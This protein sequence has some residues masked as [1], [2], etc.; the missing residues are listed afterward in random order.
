MSIKTIGD[1]ADPASLDEAYVR[2]FEAAGTADELLR[3]VY[4]DRPG[5]GGQSFGEMLAAFDVLLERIES[6]SWPATSASALNGRVAADYADPAVFGGGGVGKYID[7]Q[8][9]PA[10]RTWDFTNWGSYRA[11]SLATMTA[12]ATEVRAGQSITVRDEGFF[13]GET[14][15]LWIES[16]PVLL[17]TAVAGADGVVSFQVAI[18]A[19]VGGGAHTLRLVGLTS[20]T[21]LTWALTVAAMPATGGTLS[22]EAVGG[23]LALLVLGAG[24]VLLRRRRPAVS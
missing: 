5:H 8:P 4:I 16:T 14:V 12:S 19:E 21:Q 3:S 13:S 10:L 24:G 20:G 17:G 22:A 7:D 1:S 23:A 11:P 2:T 18:P 15:Q 9:T 6:G